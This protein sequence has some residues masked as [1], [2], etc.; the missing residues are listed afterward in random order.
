ML[1][2]VE[3]EL[4]DEAFV[5]VGVHSPKFPSERD[6][7]LV[8]EAVRRHGI[9]HPVVVAGQRLWDA[10]AVRAWPTLVVVG[11]DGLI[12]GAASGEPDRAPLLLALRGVLQRQ[13]AMLDPAPL[14]LR[15][16]AGPPARLP[17]RVGSP[18]APK[19]SMW[20]TPATTRCAP[21]T[22]TA[23]RSAPWRGRHRRGLRR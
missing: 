18:P 16:E 17:I 9:S 19:R 11:A 22:W 21:W 6:P 5:V 20:P 8:A 23:G 1:A 14:P 13:L 3:R 2:A 7:S 4:A 10:C 12:V 15:P